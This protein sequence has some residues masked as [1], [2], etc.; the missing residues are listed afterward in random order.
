MI[1]FDNSATTYPKPLSVINAVNDSLRYYSA[2]PGRSGHTMSLKTAEKIFEC[3]S[4]V[5]KLFNLKDESKVVFTPGCT[6]AL[7]IVIKGILKPGDHCVISNLEHN[8][9]LRPLDKLKKQNISY[10]VAEVFENDD[11]K[12]IESFRSV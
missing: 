2:N 12:T 7:N 9:V 3:R 1:Y 4:T 11:D 8:S 5:C 10:S 6:H